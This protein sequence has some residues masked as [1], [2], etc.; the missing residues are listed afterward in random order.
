MSGQLSQLTQ[1]VKPETLAKVSQSLLI[2]VIYL[3]FY[4][5]IVAASPQISFD[6][7]NL[8]II[9]FSSAILGNFAHGKLEGL[10][11]F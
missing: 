9:V 6:K 7:Y 8:A 11:L 1:Y 3:C 10:R 4:A 5:V 2:L